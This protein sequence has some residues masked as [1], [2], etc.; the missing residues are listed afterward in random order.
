METKICKKCNQKKELSLFVKNKQCKDG[1]ENQ[2]K[3]CNKKYK[4]EHYEKNK[5]KIKEATKRYAKENEDKIREYRRN[6]YQDET[7]KVK[8]RQKLYR[9]KN[10]DLI[11]EKKKEYYYA[12]RKQILIKQKQYNN[13]NPMISK[14]WRIKNKEHIKKYRDDYKKRDYAIIAKRISE[15]KRR[16]NKQSSSTITV[17]EIKE[18]IKK[19]KYICYW[20]GKNCKKDFHLDHYIPLSKGGTHSLNNIVVS[21]PKCNLTKSSKDPLEFAQSKG[22]LL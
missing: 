7:T 1:F 19:S 9:E 20:C 12:N 5:D 15:H 13:D 14:E 21:C 22:K 4:K 11:L 2:C 8:E 17:L 18:L 6:R 10:S 16:I 3:E